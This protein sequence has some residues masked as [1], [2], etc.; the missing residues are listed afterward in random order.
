[1]YVG[2]CL[3]LEYLFFQGFYAKP[4]KNPDGT[5][6]LMNWDC[7]VPGKKGVSFTGTIFGLSDDLIT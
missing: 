2:Y 6:D 4:R 1:M 7:G 3:V 5:M